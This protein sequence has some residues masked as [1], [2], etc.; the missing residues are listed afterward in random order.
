MT[1]VVKQ[2][3]IEY[4]I[5]SEKKKIYKCVIASLLEILYPHKIRLLFIRKYVISINIIY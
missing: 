3:I 5:L 1:L 2:T 4:Q